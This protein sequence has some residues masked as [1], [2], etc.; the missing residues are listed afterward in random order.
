LALQHD[1]NC[2][3]E[4]EG[5]AN[6]LEQLVVEKIYTHLGLRARGSAALGLTV[7]IRLPHPQHRSITVDRAALQHRR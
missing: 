4:L 2:G 3:L 7:A 1:R 5:I 6:S